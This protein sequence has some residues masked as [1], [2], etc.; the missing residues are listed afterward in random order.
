M[1]RGLFESTSIFVKRNEY[2]LWSI[3][4]AYILNKDLNKTGL[5]KDDFNKYGNEFVNGKY[6]FYSTDKSQVL[7]GT[8]ITFQAYLSF[9]P[10]LIYRRSR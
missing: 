2:Y 3:F 10:I 9:S 7:L 8:V 4:S 5:N 1:T 6:V